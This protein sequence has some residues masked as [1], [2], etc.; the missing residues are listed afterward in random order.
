MGIPGFN[1]ATSV[2]LIIAQRLARKLCN[3]CKKPIE[4]P[5]ETLVKEGSA[6]TDRQFH[7]LRA[8]RLRSLQRR[9]QG[10]V[11]IYEVVK[12]TSELQ[13][14]IMA[15]GNSLEIDS[16]MRRDGFDDLRTSGLHRAMQGI[17]SL[18]EINRVTKD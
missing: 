12:N 18:E 7:D 10:R 1:I 4:I 2:S 16:Q 17:T 14:L 9:L 8:G 5:R 6:G 11:G 13:R 15:E 3:H